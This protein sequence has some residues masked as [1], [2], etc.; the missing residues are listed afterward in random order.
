VAF[1]TACLL[2]ALPAGCGG[3]EPTP[4][5]ARL[6]AE[7]T[8]PAEPPPSV[9]ETVVA[10]LGDSITA[11]SP[12]WDPDPAVRAQIGPAADPTSRYEYWV[13]RRMPEARFRNCGV[14]GER[15]DEIAIRLD[16]CAEGADV[17]IVQGGINDIAQMR[18]V[19]TAARNLRAM[20]T[21]GKRQGLRVALVDVL[22]WNN[23]GPA[24]APRI[25]R[26]NK[27]IADI[28]ADEGVPV[29]PWYEQ[30]EDPQ[31]PGNMKAEWTID[32]DHP[33]VEGYRRL[34]DVVELP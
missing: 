1:G 30:L 21:R 12:L 7:R 33:S 26:L 25:R 9:G 28:G 24:A 19:R 2:F 20:V 10:A 32:G 27:L 13:Q 22:P 11:G 16:G 31:A 34:A 14:F 5:E 15:T 3:G 18:R 29:F 17:L 8:S 23:G 4:N 6:G